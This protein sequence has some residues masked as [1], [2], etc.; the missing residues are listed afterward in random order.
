[1]LAHTGDTR[2]FIDGRAPRGAPR[3]YVVQ[4]AGARGNLSPFSN[5]SSA[6]PERTAPPAPPLLFRPTDAEHPID[7]PFTS[8]SLDGR[9]EPGSLVSVDVGGTLRSVVEAGP[10]FQPIA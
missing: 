2:G 10:P 5:E 7:W 6:T 4:A 1:V 9:A 8:T 3:F